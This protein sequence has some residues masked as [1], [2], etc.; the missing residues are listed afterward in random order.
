MTGRVSSGTSGGV[1]LE[2]LAG[3]GAEWVVG[4]GRN[5]QH[6]KPEGHNFEG[7]GISRERN[8]ARSEVVNADPGT[9]KTPRSTFFRSQRRFP[10]LIRKQVWRER[11]EAMPKADV[12]LRR[13]D[14]SLEM[15]AF[16]EGNSCSMAAALDVARQSVEHSDVDVSLPSF[17]DKGLKVIATKIAFSLPDVEIEVVCPVGKDTPVF[18]LPMVIDENGEIA[19]NL[20]FT[21]LTGGVRQRRA[22]FVEVRRASDPQQCLLIAEGKMRLDEPVVLVASEK[23]V[24]SSVLLLSMPLSN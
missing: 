6:G 15:V 9:N 11:L 24:E 13:T 5:T 19:S 14:G 3:F 17:V 10:D 16:G 4:F 2:L 12:F 22:C 1:P 7:S 23:T 21:A 20:L 8:K 18:S